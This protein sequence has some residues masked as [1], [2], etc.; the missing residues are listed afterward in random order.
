MN[1]H[2]MQAAIVHGC[3]LSGHTHRVEVLLQ[4]LAVP[5]ER[6]A[7]DLPSAA[8]KQPAHMA[9][10][11]FGQAPGFFPMRGSAVGLCAA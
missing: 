8:H 11:P 6:V 5:F 10:H 1:Q 4:M 9:L 7:V 3:A 2:A